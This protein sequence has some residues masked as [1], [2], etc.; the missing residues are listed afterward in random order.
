MIKI[1]CKK[2]ADEIVEQVA[3]IPNKQKELVIFTAGDDPASAAYMKGKMK[4]CERCGIPVRQIKVES[5]EELILRIM[6][7]NTNCNTGGIIV[8]LPLPEG[9][10]EQEAVDAVRI[11]KDVDGFKQESSFLPCTPE[12]ILYILDK[13][14]G[15]LSG[16][17]VLLIGKGKLIGRPLIDLLLERGCTLTIAH[18]KTKNLNRLLEEYHDIVIT[19]VGKPKLVDLCWTDADVVID[20]GISRDENGKLCGD[21]FNFDPDMDDTKVTT[22]PNGIGLMTRAMLMKHMEK[23]EVDNG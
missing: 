18:S 16:K 7:E 22:V 4:D 20:A 13:E 9:F 19:G 5:Q 8:Q 3:R 17:T 21:C 11:D 6:M 12:G 14:V 23:V 10:D 15:D 1:D 2:Y